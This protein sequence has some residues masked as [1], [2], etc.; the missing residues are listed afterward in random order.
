M[1]T[2]RFVV[3]A[4]AVFGVAFAGAGGSPSAHAASARGVARP[5]HAPPAAIAPY[6][7]EPTENRPYAVCPPP[8]ERRVSCM[9]AAVPF[10]NGKPVV[11]PGLEGSGEKGGFSPVD[12]RSAYG[13]PN[14][15]AAGRTVAITIA[16]DDPNAASD[17]AT[18]RSRYGL[19]PCNSENGCFRRVN[20][21][22]EEGN[23]PATNS[24]WALETS[25]DL[26]M[27]S[28]T[29]PQCHILLVEADS[30]YL[31]DLSAAVETT[32]TLGAQVVSNSW[33]TEE[34]FGESEEDHYFEH[35][36][37]PMLFASGDWGYGVYYPAASPGVVAVGGTSLTKSGN[38]RG[39]QETAWSG[40]GSGCS[41][42]E[43]KPAWQKDEGC[44]GRTVT[45]VSAVADPATPVSVYDSFEESGWVLLGGTSV[46]TPIMAGVEA[47]SS[48][49]VRAM[50]PAAFDRIGTGGGMFDVTEGE[51]G[52]CGAF[53]EGDFSAT[54]LCQ[55]DVGYDGP[56]GWGTPPG[57]LSLPVAITEAASTLA[58]VQV[59]LH[60]TVNPG[61]LA[62]EYR[63]EYGETTSYGESVPVPAADAGG[64]S[65]YVAVNQA[66]E[67]LKGQTPYHYRIVA[68][69]SAGTFPGNDRV[70]GTTPPTV[71]TGSAD[72]IGISHAVLHAKVNPEGLDTAYYFEYGPTTSYGFKAPTRA[73]DAGSGTSQVGVSGAIG[74][75][76]G[77][78]IYHYRVVAKN[79]AG[80][81]YGADRTFVT[82]PA[83]W[84]EEDLPQPPNS[85]GG[86]WATGVS[87]VGSEECVAVGAN[88]N[89]EVHTRAT[90]AEFWDGTS[91]TVMDT[92]NPPGL[93]EGW[94]HNWYAWLTSVSCVSSTACVAVG[95]YRDPSE[96]VKPMAEV[97]DGEEWTLNALLWPEGAQL[98]QLTGVSCAK[99]TG[100][101]IVG[102]YQQSGKEKALILRWDGISWTTQAAPVPET[103][104]SSWL[105]GVSCSAT[106]ACTAVGGYDYGTNG[107]A[108]LALRWNGSAW[109]IQPTPNPGPRS[110]AQLHSVSCPTATACTAVGYYRIG[111]TDVGLA[112]NWDGSSWT[113][114]F[115][116]TPEEEGAL[117]NVSCISATV[118]TAV[119]SYYGNSEIDH[120]WHSLVERRD[121][122]NW[123][124]L[125][126]ATFSIS[127]GWWHEEP[128]SGV[129]CA[130]ACTAVGTRLAAPEGQMATPVAFAEHELLPP[131]ASFSMD[132]EEP[133][134]GQLV[135]FD[136]SSSS[137]PD[138][139]IESYE[140]DFG[141]GGQ[142]TGVEPSH[143]Y[144]RA[145]DYTITLTVTNAA[146]QTGK[147]SH[148]V[149]VRNVR[150]IAAFEVTT[151]SPFATQPVSFDASSSSDSDGA[152]AG[153]EWN[154]GD[155]SQGTGIN[156]SHAYAQAGEYTVTLIVSDD[157][158]ASAQ[159][160]HQ[161]DV[162]EPPLPDPRPGENPG[163]KEPPK[164]PQVEPTGF[165]IKH[166]R[167]GRHG[168]ILLT[169]RVWG[170][171]R[172]SADA[173]IRAN[174]QTQ[175]Y[176]TGSLGIGGDGFYS[177]TLAPRSGG[178]RALRSSSDPRFEITV[179]FQ[180]NAGEPIVKRKAFVLRR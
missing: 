104:T 140:W 27:V 108:T 54:Y 120:G 170:G 84:T 34:F 151:K 75:L 10:R 172:L 85:G 167:G 103:A 131:F 136:G 26:D 46:A 36:G 162:A 7:R 8:T 12:L 28:A 68:M 100:C 160:A 147:I 14:A 18:Y 45:D 141:D 31:S 42:Y 174:G 52:P 102:R 51:N 83:R 70:F 6:S 95:Y 110:D 32:V 17:L 91:W 67:G 73:G 117:S 38:S 76:S 157:E 71:V 168:K 72:E 156:P 128:L 118:C 79:V 127:P 158:G 47:L 149:R 144:V 146:G 112:A 35:P 39:W 176:G 155:G 113:A 164:P 123:S 105:S 161:V 21:T 132:D 166:I 30:S 98:T 40:A 41:A 20:Q 86:H 33:A 93:D 50:G 133:F 58:A 11:G 25:L 111:Y 101:T 66:L 81:V 130:E 89:L 4:V 53:S 37:I 90:L 60:G 122:N 154:F 169:L 48:E 3:A 29:C 64:G 142:A 56:T 99:A 1:R 22:G 125:E 62:T 96:I 82:A 115:P 119:G 49:D 138:G 92:P 106:T 87:C 9:A 150:P 74:G 65:G 63:F 143:S 129:S 124:L 121:G 55:S 159:V 16:Y 5:E 126:A 173:R 137:E 107:T 77:G 69:N 88:W 152:I 135:T 116:P 13:L 171:G 175:P 145:G 139:T 2:N 148:L 134:S 165:G 57:P 61:G 153:Y 24:G 163:E 78:G 180:P 178:F 94:S 114:Q 109:A 177:L 43:T 44:N 59:I 179:S 15:G 23:Y 80:V 19:P 97:W